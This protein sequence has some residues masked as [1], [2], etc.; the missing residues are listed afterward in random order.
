MHKLIDDGH[1]FGEEGV[2]S[3]LGVWGGCCY[4][5]RELL[6]NTTNLLIQSDKLCAQLKKYL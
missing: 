3:H 4:D 5:V 6:S 2:E 1:V